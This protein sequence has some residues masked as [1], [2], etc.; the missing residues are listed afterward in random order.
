MLFKWTADRFYEESEAVEWQTGMG[1]A[2]THLPKWACRQ[3]RVVDEVEQTWDG[4]PG[5]V[6][7]RIVNGERLQRSEPPHG[8]HSSHSCIIGFLGGAFRPSNP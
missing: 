8:Q 1:L 5:L 7:L 2:W 6:L 4:P 3:H